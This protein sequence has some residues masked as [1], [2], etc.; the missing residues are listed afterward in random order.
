MEMF[1]GSWITLTPARKPRKSVR[2]AWSGSN[3]TIAW[4]L[5]QTF[6]LASCS[7]IRSG[8]TRALGFPEQ[9]IHS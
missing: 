4:G 7:A 3:F 8:G 1:D 5:A 9:T 6:S 2:A